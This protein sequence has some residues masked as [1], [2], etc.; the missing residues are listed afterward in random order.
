VFRRPEPEVGLA[1][2]VIRRRVL[3][4]PFLLQH[5]VRRHLAQLPHVERAVVGQVL[6]R[7]DT[8]IDLRLEGRDLRRLRQLPVPTRRP[9]LGPPDVDVLLGRGGVRGVAAALGPAQEDTEVRVEGVLGVEGFQRVRTLRGLDMMP[10]RLITWSAG[11]VAQG[12]GV[13]TFRKPT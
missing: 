7:L 12:A 11:E 6:V 2:S 10:Q 1:Y 9:D 8:V 4:L 13:V 3:G 5:R